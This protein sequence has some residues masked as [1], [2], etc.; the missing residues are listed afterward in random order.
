M[1]MQLS[2]KPARGALFVIVA[3]I[4]ILLLFGLSGSS[5]FGNA[6]VASDAAMSTPEGKSTAG[7]G[8]A[9]EPEWYATCPFDPPTPT[10]QGEQPTHTPEPTPTCRPTHT[11]I[12]I[13]THTLIPTS[14][15]YPDQPDPHIP[16][17]PTPRPTSTTIPTRTPTPTTISPLPTPT[18]VS[19]LP[20]P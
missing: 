8:N 11:P 1:K 17:T 4:S 12:V 15:P 10:P 3:M 2:G 14:T 13:P 19:P 9:S 20:P 7:A 5:L 6:E 18:T 16:P